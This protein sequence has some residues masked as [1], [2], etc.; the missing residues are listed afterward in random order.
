MKNFKQ[1]LAY[2]MKSTREMIL[3]LLVFLVVLVLFFKILPQSKSPAGKFPI[4]VLELPAQHNG[5]TFDRWPNPQLTY[6]GVETMS[7]FRILRQPTDLPEMA[8]IHFFQPGFADSISVNSV[9]NTW[10]KKGMRRILI[11]LADSVSYPVWHFVDTGEKSNLVKFF[12][13][14]EDD[15]TQTDFTLLYLNRYPTRL[16]FTAGPMDVSS[17]NL[18]LTREFRGEF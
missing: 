1:L 9:W 15:T 14:A 7:L 2:F 6:Q 4:Q 5:V 18:Y 3:L 8:L 11:N 10:Q 17:V 16:Y 12:K 13:A